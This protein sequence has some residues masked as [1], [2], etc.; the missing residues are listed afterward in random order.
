MQDFFLFL[1]TI[2]SLEVT[3]KVKELTLFSVVA[4]DAPF[5]V[6]RSRTLVKQK[7]KPQFVPRSRTS[8]PYS[9]LDKLQSKLLKMHHNHFF[10]VQS[11][12]WDYEVGPDPYKTI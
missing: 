3:L 7:P 4:S 1:C 9:N 10:Q 5:F 12:M 2:M 11:F 6:K 8:I